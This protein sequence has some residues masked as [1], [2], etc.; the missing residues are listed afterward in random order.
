MSSTPTARPATSAAQGPRADL[1]PKVSAASGQHGT[2][3]AYV[4]AHMRSCPAAATPAPATQTPVICYTHG[5]VLINGRH[6]I[7]GGVG[8]WFERSRHHHLNVA[9]PLPSMVRKD[10]KGESVKR[11]ELWAIIRALQSAP[12]DRSLTII[13]D[14][15][16]AV[17]A[18]NDLVPL[19]ESRR[20]RNCKRQPVANGDLIREVLQECD[21]R[22][23]R[24]GCKIKIEL[25]S[26]D[27]VALDGWEEARE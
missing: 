7:R 2:R 9:E 8:V 1:A 15:S 11:A 10:H 21:A 18:I 22:R 4:P 19:W 20:W 14:S 27:D 23:L 16:Y 12:A 3:K 17:R 6:S 5:Q 26:E 13:T 24:A 25:L